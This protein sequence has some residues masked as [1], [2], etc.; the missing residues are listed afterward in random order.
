M[1]ALVVCFTVLAVAWRDPATPRRPRASRRRRRATAAGRAVPRWAG[2]S[3]RGRSGSLLRVLG[4]LFLA[5]VAMVAVAGQDLLTN[6]IFGI[7]YVWWWVG[8]V[9]FSLLLGPVWQRDQP[10]AAP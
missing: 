9:P 4:L 3:T 8:L 10:G 5:Y 6:P 2:W 7:F 1:A